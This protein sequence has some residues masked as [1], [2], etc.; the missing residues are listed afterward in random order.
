M[1]IVTQY[2][3]NTFCWIDLATSDID[4]AKSFYS[5]LFG[6]EYEDLSAGDGFLYSMCRYREQRVCAMFG[7]NESMINQRVPSHWSSYVSVSDVDAKVAKAKILGAKVPMVCTVMDSGRMAKVQDPMGAWFSLWQPRNHSGAALVNQPNTWCWNELSV[8]HSQ[9]ALAFYNKL[10]DWRGETRP[11][12]T[13]GSYITIYNNERMV[14][15]MLTINPDWVEMPV[16]WEVYFAVTDCAAATHRATEL[17]ARVLV[18]NKQVA[19]IGVL[20]V[21]QDPTQGT[22]TIIAL[23]QADPPPGY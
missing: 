15:G 11:S 20:S 13:D 6:W 16:H 21:L 19:E 23:E 3:V 8:Y 7:M 14:G 22:F 10:L 9:P 18:A 2:P 1:Q 5:G 17:G 12:G 4:Q